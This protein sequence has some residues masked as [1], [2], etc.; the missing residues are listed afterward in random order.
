M[1]LVGVTK[2]VTPK[3]KPYR[4]LDI[5]DRWAKGRNVQNL[6]F[7][8]FGHLVRP[9]IVRPRTMGVTENAR[10]FGRDRLQ[11]VAGSP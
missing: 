6:I 11:P 5:L 9:Q 3:S 10:H 4:G 8:Y 1:G 2:T 7:G